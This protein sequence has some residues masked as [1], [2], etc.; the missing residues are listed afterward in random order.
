[1]GFGPRPSRRER[2]AS[3][4]FRALFRAHGRFKESTMRNFVSSICRIPIALVALVLV[5]FTTGAAADVVIYSQGFEAG[6]GSYA[7]A[8]AALW[9]W[10]TPTNVGPPAAHSGLSCWGT[11]LS[12]TVPQAASRTGSITSPAIPVPAVTANQTVRASFWL[13]SH[14]GDM[15]DRGEFQTSSDGTSFTK[16]I[17]FY[18][19]MAG[20]WQRYEFDVTPYAG[21]NLYL[22][23]YLDKTRDSLAIPGLYVDDVAVTI[24]TKPATAA[25]FTLVGW[26]D[27]ASSASCPWVFTWDGQQF[28]RDN[29]IYS[30]GRYPAGEY[31]DFYLLNRPLVAANG[32]YDLEVREVESEDSFTDMVGLLTVDHRPGVAVGPDQAGGIHGYDTRSLVAPARARDGAGADVLAAVATRDEAGVP[33]YD[34]DVVDLDFPEVDPS[35]G[36]HL[37]VRIKGFV[38]GTGEPRPYTGPPAVVVNVAGA[39]GTWR[40][41]GRVLPRFDWSLGVFDLTPFLAGRT[42]G[43]KVRLQSIS[44]ETRYHE[45]DFVALAPGAEPALEIVPSTMLSATAKGAD[46]RALLAATDGLRVEMHPDD[47]FAVSFSETGRDLPERDFILVSRGYYIPRG[48]TF[49]IYTWDGSAWIQ[50]DA[51]TTSGSADTTMTFD[52]SLFLPDPAGEFKVRVWQDYKYEYARINFAGLVYGTQTGALTYARSLRAGGNVDILAQ[53]SAID[54]SYVSYTSS[55]RVRDRWSEYRFTAIDTV[56]PPS[57][58][59]VT[60]AGNTI[61]WV[62]TD[63]QSLPQASW[64]V[65]VWTAAGG[66][67]TIMWNPP[68]GTGTQTS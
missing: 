58:N 28:V 31:T 16:V 63:P 48:G 29:D 19:Q 44:H 35:A 24:R 67:G 20:G 13:W 60:A 25:S 62:Y 7:V 64:E 1:M 6:N 37:V 38:Y 11:N 39:D 40:E 46:V 22:R 8:G 45:I 14:L 55:P 42:D 53:T 68:T 33:A 61:G 18:E 15:Y 3:D 30:V 41:A 21:G 23:F 51:R 49:L 32:R 9:E 59:P 66:S 56:L 65:E 17:K 34:G 12:G 57:T 4:A 47:A 2:Q 36:A 50:R 43:V 27:P 10:G 54:S 5:A 52:L 26:E